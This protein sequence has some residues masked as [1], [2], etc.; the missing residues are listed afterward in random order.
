M[1]QTFNPKQEAKSLKKEGIKITRRGKTWRFILDK[2]KFVLPYRDGLL[3]Y[4]IAVDLKDPSYWRNNP[5]SRYIRNESVIAKREGEIWKFEYWDGRSIFRLC[6]KHNLIIN[7]LMR[8]LI[9]KEEKKNSQ[10]SFTF[11]KAWY[12][13]Q[14]RKES[15]W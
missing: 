13:A 4:Q 10:K 14:F 7:L 11:C 15:M 1:K 8:K 9:S 6:R 12:A 2:T 3:L 5:K